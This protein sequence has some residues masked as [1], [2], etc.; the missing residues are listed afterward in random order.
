MFLSV[1]ITGPQET[2]NVH[3]GPLQTVFFFFL[4]EGFYSLNA[5]PDLTEDELDR[6]WFWIWIWTV[7][8]CN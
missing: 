6:V 5:F 2:G 1:W 7:H 8:C 4:A 3:Q